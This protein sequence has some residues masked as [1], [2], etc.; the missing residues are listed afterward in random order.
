MSLLN[1]VN[2]CHVLSAF[3]LNDWNEDRKARITEISILNELITG[4]SSDSSSLDF[5]IAQHNQAIKSCEIVLKALNEVEEYHDSLVLRQI[6]GSVILTEKESPFSA[7][8][9]PG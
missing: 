7:I 5:N 8:L 6:W 3:S 9:Q 1:V 4:L 2:F